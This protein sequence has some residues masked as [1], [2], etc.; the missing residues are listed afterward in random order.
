MKKTLIENLKSLL[1]HKEVLLSCGTLKIEKLI[2]Q[3][4]FVIS[5]N[6]YIRFFS[7]LNMHDSSSFTELDN[8]IEDVMFHVNKLEGSFDEKYKVHQELKHSFNKIL[9]PVANLYLSEENLHSVNYLP[10][11]TI[12]VYV[13]DKEGHLSKIKIKITE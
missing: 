7:S 13:K 6:T 12:H 8:L 11:N 5:D 10:N 1:N 4:V 9:F 2:E 3:K